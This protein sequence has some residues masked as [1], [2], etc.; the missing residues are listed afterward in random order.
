M[1]WGGL[2]V[3][4][5]ALI[6]GVVVLFLLV[7]D[8]WIHCTRN[9]AGCCRC[10][11]PPPDPLDGP[12]DQPDIESNEGFHREHDRN[13]E[14]NWHVVALQRDETQEDAD[15]VIR[16]REEDM[17]RREIERASKEKVKIVGGVATVGG[18][19]TE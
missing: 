4:L 11:K 13:F 9:A 15:E 16:R 12:P 2:S 6:G 8:R 14:R 18:I 10:K 19:Q 3:T 7:V 17:R 1:T 5:W